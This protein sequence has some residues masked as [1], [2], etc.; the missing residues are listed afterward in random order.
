[1]QKFTKRKTLKYNNITHIMAIPKKKNKFTIP[2]LYDTSVFADGG[3]TLDIFGNIKA[4]N[5]QAAIGQGLGVVQGGMQLGTQIANNLSTSGIG[6]E[7]QGTNDINRNDILGT[8]TS[9]DSKQ[10][11]VFGAAGQ[12]AMTGAQAGQVFGPEGALIGAGVGALAGGISS[13]FGNE[14]KQQKAD[15]AQQQ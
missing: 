9:V 3:K 6:N 7:V 14:A 2:P 4:G 8:N 11:N 15:L 10:T 5:S 13:I 1:M 12:G